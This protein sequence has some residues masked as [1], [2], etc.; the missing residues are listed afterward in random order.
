MPKIEIREKDLTSAGNFSAT[1]NAVYIPGY[2]N[3]GPINKPTLC[4]TLDQFRQVF[5]S[6]PYV[7]REN[8][9]WS[10]SGVVWGTNAV[11]DSMS[12][13]YQEGE[14][15]KSYIMATELLKLGMP[16]IYERV[17][18]ESDGNKDSWTAYN[19]DVEVTIQ[20]D[21]DIKGVCEIKSVS[22]GFAGTYIKF[23]IQQVT[24]VGAS[25]LI[26]YRI[27]VK[28]DSDSSLGISSIDAIDTYI[29]FNSDVSKKYSNTALVSSKQTIIDNSGLISLHFDDVLSSSILQETKD[30]DGEYI[31]L[32][33]G[34]DRDRTTDEFKYS[35]VYD[36]L[37]QEG[38]D[39]V[40]NEPL[41]LDKLL[42]KG[43]FAIKFVTSGAYPTLELSGDR[44]SSISKK[45]MLLSA[46]RG[47][48]TTLLDHTPRNDRPL[49]G[50]SSVYEFVKSNFSIPTSSTTF[51]EDAN[52]YTSIFTPYGI[53]GTSFGDKMLPASFGYL[54]A[55][56]VQ[57][58]QYN[59][60]L[61]TAGVTRGIVPGLKSLCQ[62]LT[63]SIADSYQGRDEITI[64]PITNIKPY[65]L[66]IWGARTLKNNK[67]AGDLTATSFLNIRQLTND[68]KRQVWAAAK[69]LTFEQNND[70]LWIKFKNKITPLLDNMI[71]GN[72]ISA[73][74]LKRQKV[75]K[76]ATVKAVVRLYAVEPVEDWDIT[77][78]LADDTT[79]VL[80]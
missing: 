4:E 23:K 15:E 38:E 29:T 58:N 21:N 2:A 70:I 24:D 52:I 30:A 46:N 66:T 16:V 39:L 41:G 51:G 14:Q 34:C 79:E 28:R 35:Y 78:E 60:W 18:N 27:S 36:H 77:I 8:Q 10:N 56:A 68:V 45:M 54:S 42:D 74:E 65:G 6:Q 71:N 31:F 67:L 19:K 25:N 20:P 33:L 7:I 47:D 11:T 44:Y 26:R 22:P 12:T 62:S 17:F 75:D 61:A 32:G 53:Y 57:A 40:T 76:K 80:G 43:E 1:T 13:F 64:N 37:Y 5:G 55:F 72:G 50:Q 59:N 49:T 9:M 48:C 69:S 63:N 3:V 73:Y